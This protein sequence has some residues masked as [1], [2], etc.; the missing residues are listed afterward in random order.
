MKNFT[1]LSTSFASMLLFACS[2][3]SDTTPGAPSDVSV[4]AGTTAG[5]AVVSFNPPASS[6]SSAITGYTVTA[7]PG[8]ITATG[9]SSPI[10]VS[11]LTAKTAYTYSV[12]ASNGSGSSAATT[13]GALSFYSVVETFYEPMTQPNNSVFT[14]TFTYDATNKVVS[15]LAGSLTEAMSMSTPMTTV[16]LTHQLSTTS[17]TLGGQS[18]LLVTTFLLTTTN[19]FDP[20]GFAPGG[21]EYYGLSTHAKNPSQGGVGNAYAMIFVNATDPTTALE[22]AQIDMLAYADCTAGGMMGSSC[23]T[24]TSSAGYGTDGTMMGYPESQVTTQQ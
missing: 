11:G 21:T 3:S 10:T 13:T 14:G 9:T 5:T 20:S 22:S 2:S 18:G 1:R 12:T 4:A 23:M 15:N 16:S 24:G 19:T 7:N 6:G 8:G 17:V